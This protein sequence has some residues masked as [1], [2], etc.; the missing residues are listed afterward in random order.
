MNNLTTFNTN[1]KYTQKLLTTTHLGQKASKNFLKEHYFK[2]LNSHLNTCEITPKVLDSFY[3]NTSFKVI[4]VTGTAGKGSTSKMIAKGLEDS[5]FKVGLFT[6]PHILQVHERIQINSKCINEDDFENLLKKYYN[7]YPQIMFCEIL[8]LVAIEYFSIQNVDYAVFE[9]FVGG[10]YDTTNIFNSVAT[11]ITSIGLDHQHLLGNSYEKILSQKLGVIRENVPL[12]TRIEHKLINLKTQEIGARYI[13]V[14]TLKNTNLGGEF[15][16]ENAGI[17]YE[18]LR[19]L[20][21][22]SS[23][24]KKSLMNITIR[25]RLEYISSNILVDCAHNGLSLQRLEN[26]LKK[27]LFKQ[28]SFKKKI[29]IFAISNYKNLKDFEFFFNHFDSIICTKSSIFKAKD[30]KDEILELDSFLQ[31]KL[32]FLSLE[33]VFE[34]LN[35]FKRKENTDEFCMVTGSVFLVAD[36]LEYFE[37]KKKDIEKRDI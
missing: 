28:L 13:K 18:V 34:Y 15:Q 4:H 11:V 26:Y 7:L 2:G 12:F 32:Q 27:E 3:I 14:N 33:E 9:V 10:E 19:Y 36:V 31:D 24:I 17:A 1:L 25:G 6:S 5:G 20:G 8:T 22:D 21:V 29:L 35:F 30:I 16:R 23:S 37:E